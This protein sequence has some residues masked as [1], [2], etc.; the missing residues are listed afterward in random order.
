MQNNS[1]PIAALSSSMQTGHEAKMMTPTKKL[2]LVVLGG[3][4]KG[5]HIEQ[6]DVRWVVGVSI[7]A[8]LPALRQEWI[9]LRRG[10]HI[11][12][13]RCVQQVDGHRVEVIESVE[14]PSSADE[15]RLWFVNLGGYAATSMAEK[16][17][18]DVLVARS[19]ASA[20]AQAR[21]RWL[22]GM[23]HVHKDDL[24]GVEMDPGLD[25][26]LPIQGNGQWS[27]KLTA[28]AKKENDIPAPD[29]YGYWKI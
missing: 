17:Y 26:L 22:K 6:H 21:K 7:E 14:S 20:K 4:C 23:E 13:Y 28:D 16:H 12:S 27:L 18:F 11:D 9:G 25:D 5:C 19:S 1:S 8:T 10:L 15:P 24:H 2:F 3:R 29:W